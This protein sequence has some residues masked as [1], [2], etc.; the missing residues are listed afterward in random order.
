MRHGRVGKS[1][2]ASG[3]QETGT[4]SVPPS[5]GSLGG[6]GW[7]RAWALGFAALSLLVGAY[8]FVSVPALRVAV[9]VALAVL[10]PL[11]VYLY[12]RLRN[13][14]PASNDVV[15]LFT[16]VLLVLG[17]VFALNFPPG[18]VPDEGYHFVHA[19]KY[20][21]LMAPG[22]EVDSARRE[23]VRFMDDDLT[24]YVSE[25]AWRNVGRDFTV[26]ARL[27]GYVSVPSFETYWYPGLD[28]TSDPP[29]TRLFSAVGI[30]LSRLLGL[31]GIMLFYIGR[32][33]NLLVG[34][35]LV[36]LAVRIAPVGKNAMMCVSLLPITLHVL[37]SYSY[38]STVIGL[39]FLLL[40]LTL[41]MLYGDG[42]IRMRHLAAYLAVAMLLAPCKVVYTALVLLVPLVPSQRF[43]SRRGALVFKAA[44]FGLPAL[45]ILATRLPTMVNMLFPGAMAVPAASSS[46]VSGPGHATFYTASYILRSPV[47]FLKILARTF[48]RWGDD[49]LLH[50]I[51]GALGWLQAELVANRCETVMLSLLAALGLVSDPSER[52]YPRG[53]ERVLF[54]VVFALV[55]FA[56]EMSMFV[57]WTPEGEPVIQGVQGRY[58]IPVLTLV[59]LS[60][61][62]PSLCVPRDM[63]LPM[64]IAFGSFNCLYLARIAFTVLGGS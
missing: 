9:L 63:K 11:G 21:N 8:L 25:E 43:A 53:R 62:N 59:Y 34:A 45:A 38:D 30:N 16:A 58:F 18:T 12:A 40:A 24:F 32:L 51:G 52:V 29:Q 17:T 55:V 10:M 47:G 3:A 23:D 7:T 35:A 36:V 46:G 33:C 57:G 6:D 31:S 39:S 61:R 50:T 37:G 44:A 28:V 13:L 5:S 49:Y 26:L 48:W 20:A 56:I 27:D 15:P 19:Y 42:C 64:L 54:V 14:D 2:S 22:V 4:V 60:V 41:R 1:V